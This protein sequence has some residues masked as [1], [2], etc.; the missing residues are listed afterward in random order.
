M[1]NT[2][3]DKIIEGAIIKLEESPLFALT[4]CGKELAHSNFWAWLMKLPD[5]KGRH[6]FV[7]AFL[8]GFNKQHQFVDVTREEGNRDLTI[9][10]KK[11]GKGKSYI[12]ENKLKSIPTVKQLRGYQNDFHDKANPFSGG[13]LTGIEDT[14][15]SKPEEWVFLSYGSISKSI[16]TINK[17]FNNPYQKIITDYCTDLDSIVTI[18]K[19]LAAENQ[20]RYIWEAPQRLKDIRMADIYLKYEEEK[21]GKYLREKIEKTP[22]LKS[23][24]WG[25]PIVERAFNNSKP[26]ISIIYCDNDN[27]EKDEEGRG[28]FGIQIEGLDFRYYGGPNYPESPLMKG[29]PTNRHDRNDS[30]LLEKTEIYKA[31]S[32][33][34]WFLPYS[35]LEKKYRGQKTSMSKLFLAYK[36]NKYCH[37]YQYYTIDNNK[38]EN[39]TYDS[40]W[41]KV[42]VALLEAKTVIDN[43]SII[44]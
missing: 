36:T 10:C 21:F 27:S 5:E 18:L 34:G 28:R 7:D 40:L 39:T 3:I 19:S 24:K 8:P 22:K 32:R 44:F 37:A 30:E 42:L 12:I 29:F 17:K 2:G 11:N 31:F 13:I 4:L 20:N 26:T 41:D 15:E 35:S 43:G 23:K 9:Y 1:G 6:P 16:R 33:C 38:P 25:K 14:L